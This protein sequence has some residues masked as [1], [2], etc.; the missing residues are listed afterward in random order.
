MSFW[1][2]DSR[3]QAPEMDQSE[4]EMTNYGHSESYFRISHFQSNFNLGISGASPGMTDYS[5]SD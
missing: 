5:H 4:S 3:G 2:E 1:F